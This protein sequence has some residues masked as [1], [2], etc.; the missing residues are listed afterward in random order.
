[1]E[2]STIKMLEESLGFIQ[3]VE[4]MMRTS[5]ST[6]QMKLNRREKK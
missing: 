2:K 3:F 4:H 6:D 5:A 1:M